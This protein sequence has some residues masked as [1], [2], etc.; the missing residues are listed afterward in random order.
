VTKCR[1]DLYTCSEATYLRNVILQNHGKNG[2][3]MIYNRFK[4]LPN[5]VTNKTNLAG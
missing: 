1:I 5:C 4:K 2:C 3:L